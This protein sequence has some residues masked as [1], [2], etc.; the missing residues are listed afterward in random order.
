[1]EEIRIQLG[2]K[3]FVGDCVDKVAIQIADSDID[4]K[5]LETMNRACNLSFSSSQ[6]N[7]ELSSEDKSRLMELAFDCY[8]KDQT[9]CGERRFYDSIISL[10]NMGHSLDELEELSTWDLI[11]LCEDEGNLRCN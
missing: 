7:V 8:R 1:M 10:I 11:A 4:Y 6:L 3:V 9:E 2:D 5:L